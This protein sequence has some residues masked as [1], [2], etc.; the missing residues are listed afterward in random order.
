MG[1][2][3][4]EFEYYEYINYLRNEGYNIITFTQGSSNMVNISRWS[5]VKL[6]F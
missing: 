4:F 6:D 5:G 1:E 2:N 3:N